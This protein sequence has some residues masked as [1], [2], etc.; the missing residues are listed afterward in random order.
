MM[1]SGHGLLF[2]R[3]EFFKMASK[4]ACAITTYVC[5]LKLNFIMWSGLGSITKARLRLRLQCP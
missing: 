3:F 5:M 1:P 4:I 2:N